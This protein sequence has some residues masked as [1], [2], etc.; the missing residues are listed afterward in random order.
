M[1]KNGNTFFVQLSREIFTEKYSD[2]SRD[3]KWL[4]VV[5]NELEH[6]YTNGEND[7]FY[8][9][10]EDLALDAQMSLAT[11]KKYKKELVNSGL[12]QHWI[13]HL[14]MPDGKK[15]EKKFSYYRILR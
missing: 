10:N 14:I 2:L 9:S 4:Y 7:C 5:L 15:S 6:R 13:G 1:A 3:A 11:V 8:R 12:I